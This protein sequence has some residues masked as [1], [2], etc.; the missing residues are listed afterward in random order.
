MKKLLLLLGALAAASFTFAAQPA[1]A[2]AVD[3]PKAA[4]KAEEKC[5]DDSCCDDEKPADAKDAKATAQKADP[6]KD[7]KA[8]SVAKK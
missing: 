5:D 1:K 2:P 6:A 8:K 7:G 4:A 3:K